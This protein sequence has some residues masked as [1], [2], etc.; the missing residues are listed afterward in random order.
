MCWNWESSLISWLISLVTG[1]YLYKRNNKND[2]VLSLLILTYSS[3][4]LFEA[5]MWWDQKCGKLNIA[6]TNLAYFALYAHVIAIGLGLYLEQKIVLP[7]VIGL[8]F[9]VFAVL[10]K[11]D[12]KCSRPGENGHLAWGFNQTFYI[13]V[14]IAAIA[15]VFAYVRPARTAVLIAGL[16]TFALLFSYL[17]TGDTMPSYWCWVSA[18]FSFLF[19]F[20]NRK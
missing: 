9:M 6:A 15:L 7:V 18:A 20:V 1:V 11:P 16:F 5:L 19:I 10:T 8:A 12:M 4:Q 17:I 14:F 3:I 2:K 13:F